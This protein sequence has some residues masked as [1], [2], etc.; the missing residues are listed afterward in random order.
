MKTSSRDKLSVWYTPASCNCV[1]MPRIVRI[2]RTATTFKGRFGCGI[3]NVSSSS[4]GVVFAR[5]GD[6]TLEKFRLRNA[7]LAMT[8]CLETVKI[9]YKGLSSYVEICLCRGFR[10]L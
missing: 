6:V 3:C 4:S 2:A 10:F 7:V 8:L 5:P 1:L 9:S